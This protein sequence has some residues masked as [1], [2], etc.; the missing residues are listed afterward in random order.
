MHICVSIYIYV[1]LYVHMHI[2]MYACLKKGIVHIFEGLERK[3][4]SRESQE[5]SRTYLG[6]DVFVCIPTVFLE[7]PEWGSRVSP[8]MY[9]YLYIYI[10]VRMDTCICT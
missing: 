1:Y 7:F 10:H 5:H 4:Q 6:S 8:S 9:V 2:D 3:L